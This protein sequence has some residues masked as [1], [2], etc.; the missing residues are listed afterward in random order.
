[1]NTSFSPHLSTLFACI[2]IL[3]ILYY[4]QIAMKMYTLADKAIAPEEFSRA[5][6]ICTGRQLSPYVVK[7]VFQVIKSQTW[8]FG[9]EGPPPRLDGKSTPRM[10]LPPT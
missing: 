3:S 4:F 6:T 8:A 1:M 2:H 9:W 10:T 7:T 5:V